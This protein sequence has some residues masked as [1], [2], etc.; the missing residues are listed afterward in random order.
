MEGEVTAMSVLSDL[1]TQI[2][3]A[4]QKI[5]HD[6]AVNEPTI[7]VTVMSALRDLGAP[8]AVTDAMQALVR[9]LVAHFAAEQA[10]AATDA[11]APAD[12]PGE[13]AEMGS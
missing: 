13:P 2:S 5:I 10:K 9:G 11:A 4:V 3:G 7:D 6:V 8:P 12:G 1:E